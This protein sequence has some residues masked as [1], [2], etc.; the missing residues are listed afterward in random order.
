VAPQLSTIEWD[1]D[2]S[3]AAALAPA[4]IESTARFTRLARYRDWH[5]ETGDTT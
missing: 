2:R 1:G 3:R 5:S 4:A